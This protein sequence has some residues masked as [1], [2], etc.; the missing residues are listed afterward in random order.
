V[1]GSTVA[2]LS[3]RSLARKQS[4]HCCRP[5][6]RGQQCSVRSRWRVPVFWQPGSMNRGAGRPLFAWAGGRPIGEIRSD[7]VIDRKRPVTNWLMEARPVNSAR[8]I[9]RGAVNECSQLGV[10]P[11]SAARSGW[12]RHHSFAAPPPWRVRLSREARSSGRPNARPV[13]YSARSVWTGH[14]FVGKFISMKSRCPEHDQ[15]SEWGC[16]P[17]K[18]APLGYAWRQSTSG[19]MRFMNSSNIGTV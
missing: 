17:R 5:R 13:G 6:C 1:P 18:S 10:P 16:A 8:R 3:A 15:T 2:G 4:T 12:Q 14:C 11:C 9:E 7:E 19:M